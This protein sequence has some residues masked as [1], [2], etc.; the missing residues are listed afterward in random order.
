MKQGDLVFRSNQDDSVS[1]DIGIIIETG[2]F[3]GNKDVK[4]FWR[5][6]NIRTEKSEDLEVLS[7]G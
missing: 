4:V 2:V 1:S 7:E 5:E 3:T 6:S